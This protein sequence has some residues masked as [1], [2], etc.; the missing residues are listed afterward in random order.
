MKGGA[1][2]TIRMNP[3]DIMAAIDIVEAAGTWHPGMSLAQCVKTAFE[4]CMEAARLTESIPRRDGFEYERM[5]SKFTG[6]SQA[7]K[8]QVTAMME[9]AQV[10][11]VIV[12][13]QHT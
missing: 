5:V 10:G 9:A 7:R 1:V 8:K 12:D 6:V 11:R 3:Q 13:K 4:G 2:V